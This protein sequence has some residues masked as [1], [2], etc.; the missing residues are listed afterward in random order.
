MAYT[1]YPN[2][3]WKK[4]YEVLTATAFS[5]LRTSV[6]AYEKRLAT[7][8]CCRRHCCFGVFGCPWLAAGRDLGQGPLWACLVTHAVLRIPAGLFLGAVSA[9]SD[10]DI[11]VSLCPGQGPDPPSTRQI[12]HV[13]CHDG[14]PLVGSWDQ[15][16]RF[17]RSGSDKATACQVCKQQLLSDHGPWLCSDT[18]VAE[19]IKK[20][21]HKDATSGGRIKGTRGGG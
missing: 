15:E 6:K 11:P 5:C 4:N 17:R 2:L 8:C 18:L 21:L 9:E 12:L 16:S 3:L 20:G 14:C 1:L 7:R 10:D 19:D 13:F